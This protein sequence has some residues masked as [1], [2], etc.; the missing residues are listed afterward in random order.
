MT[1]GPAPMDTWPKAATGC[2]LAGEGAPTY[3]G[4]VLFRAGA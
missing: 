2:I 3:P 4:D 1:K